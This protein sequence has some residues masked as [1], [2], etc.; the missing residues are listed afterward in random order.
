[1]EREVIIEGLNILE[2]LKKE[3]KELTNQRSEYWQAQ[4]ERI[5][6]LRKNVEQKQNNLIEM[7]KTKNFASVTIEPREVG[8]MAEEWINIKKSYWL[9]R[10][11]SDYNFFNYNFKE[12]TP[13]EIEEDLLIVKERNK[14]S[15]LLGIHQ[16][17]IKI[18]KTIEE[19]KKEKE[20]MIKRHS[21]SNFLVRLLTK[22]RF[23]KELE[24]QNNKINE[25]WEKYTE[26]EEKETMYR[27]M[28]VSVSEEEMNE[29]IETEKMVSSV[30]NECNEILSNMKQLKEESGKIM[31]GF[32]EKIN[33]NRKKQESVM[34]KLLALDEGKSLEDFINDPNNDK[35]LVEIAAYILQYAGIETKRVSKTI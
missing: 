12:R 1:M 16:E 20:I 9:L 34:K 10:K 3:H 25:Q 19:L 30:I 21:N 23:Q 2:D 28:P 27:G 6:P 29:C 8:Y 24:K 5:E 26:L 31:G 33:E 32:D 35:E 15:A 22:N 13:E 14:K 7:L 4:Y 11:I 18:E 17:K